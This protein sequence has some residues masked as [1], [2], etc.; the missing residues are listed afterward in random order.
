[1]TVAQF[2]LSYHEYLNNYIAQLNRRAIFVPFDGLFDNNNSYTQA[3]IRY[4]IYIACIIRHFSKIFPSKV[5]KPALIWYQF[6]I[7]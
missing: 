3:S 6:E 2:A 1:M 4:I 7:S 5:L